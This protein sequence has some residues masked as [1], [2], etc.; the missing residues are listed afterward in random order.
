VFG[1]Q[2]EVLAV[3]QRELHIRHLHM[4]QR[5]VQQARVEL[6]VQTVAARPAVH[7]AADHLRGR[8]GRWKLMTVET[9]Y[10]VA[11]LFIFYLL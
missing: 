11:D 1:E 10:M 7:L 4:A 5:V 8:E 3:V 9:L 2:W 6:T